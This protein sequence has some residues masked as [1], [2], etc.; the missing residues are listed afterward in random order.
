MIGG[1]GVGL[2]FSRAFLKH[3]RRRWKEGVAVL[4][5]ELMGPAEA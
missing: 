4:K 1:C 5:K 2:A 3:G